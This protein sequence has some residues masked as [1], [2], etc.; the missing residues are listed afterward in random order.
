MIAGHKDPKA[1]DDTGALDATRSYLEAFDAAVASSK[2]SAEVQA[3]L[4]AKFPEAQLDII[5]QLGA[6]AAF[7]KH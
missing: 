6:D 7:A 3:K 5:L 2:T 1:K 4:K